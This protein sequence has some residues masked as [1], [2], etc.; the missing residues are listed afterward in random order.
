[1][2]PFCD[3]P[4]SPH[5][6]EWF[7]DLPET[8][9]DTLPVIIAQLWDVSEPSPRPF[10]RHGRVVNSNEDHSHLLDKV[11]RQHEYEVGCLPIFMQYKWPTTIDFLLLAERLK[12]DFI[13]QRLLLIYENPWHAVLISDLSTSTKPTTRKGGQVSARRYAALQARFDKEKEKLSYPG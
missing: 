1:M 12:G 5:R 4:L 2:C 11:C 13:L 8:T 6:I 3:E 7:R 10:N 9:W